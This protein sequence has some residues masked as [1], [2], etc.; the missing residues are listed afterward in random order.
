MARVL[1]PTQPNKN[2]RDLADIVQLSKAVTPYIRF[3]VITLG[4]NGVI[5]IKNT[6]NN[7]R[8]TQYKDKIIV[9]VYPT[10]PLEIIENVSGAGDSFSSGII[11]GILTGLKESQCISIGFKA[12]K[13]TLM[14]KNTVSPNLSNINFSD[15]KALNYRLIK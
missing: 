14:S 12:A 5:T 13:E 1:N 10:D 4:S 9:K 15:I 8:N 6:N 2:S 7:I 3:L 11:H